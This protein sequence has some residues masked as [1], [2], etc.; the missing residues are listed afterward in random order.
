MRD[1]REHNYKKPF[2]LCLLFVSVSSL[3]FSLLFDKLN[4]VYADTATLIVTNCLINNKQSPECLS[5]ITVDDSVSYALT[6]GDVLDAPFQTIILDNI[7]SAR[8]YYDS[9]GTLSGTWGVYLRDSL[10]GNIICSVDPAP[11]YASETRDFI[12]CP[13]LTTTHLA[14]GV[15][16]EIQNNDTAGPQDINLEYVYI[17]IDYPSTG[18]LTVD[19]V[20]TDGNPVLTPTVEMSQVPISIY[21]QTSTGVLGTD[22]QKIRIDNGT[23][24]ESWI[25]TIAAT[26]GPLALWSDSINSYDYND[27]TEYVGDGA[28]IDLFGGQMTI[29]PSTMIIT[30]DAMCSTTGISVGSV[31]SFSEGVVDSIVLL[32]AGASTTAPCSWDITNIGISQKIPG[33][34]PAGIYSINMTL[35]VIS[36]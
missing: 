18:S 3:Y 31:N 28:D 19:I 21:S 33:E 23:A 30:P 32:T 10:D 4:Y 15:W 29:D 36:Y 14:N 13:G 8:L 25:L 24:N 16:L 11:Q 7:T 20:D 9:Y 34:Q 26:E 17:L 35:T 27:P 1:Y 22:S 6:K 12:D 2:A 5:A